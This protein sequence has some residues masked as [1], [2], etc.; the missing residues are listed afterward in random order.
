[1]VHLANV[2]TL[3][4]Q[5]RWIVRAQGRR[6]AFPVQ[7]LVVL[8]PAID[9]GDVFQQVNHLVRE[10]VVRQFQRALGQLDAR[11]I[12][13]LHEASGECR[14]CQQGSGNQKSEF[15]NYARVLGAPRLRCNGGG[16]SAP[17]EGVWIQV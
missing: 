15:F 17:T 8:T 4:S 10:I 2:Q 13:F 16:Q 6:I 5:R 11:E 3:V 1:M 9:A 7:H 12:G 14:R